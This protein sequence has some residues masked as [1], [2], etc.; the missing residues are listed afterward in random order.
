MIVVELIEPS[1]LEGARLVE[2]CE[3]CP[4]QY[5]VHLADGRT[6]YFRYRFASWQLHLDGPAGPGI[7]GALPDADER[8]RYHGMLTLGEVL[9]VLTD[10]VPLLLKQLQP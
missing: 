6:L 2:T 9:D 4:T 1:P 5:D 3:A 8:G 10:A 7:R